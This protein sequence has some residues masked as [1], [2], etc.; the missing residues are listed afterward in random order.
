M[1]LTKPHARFLLRGSVLLIASLIL[2]WFVLADPLLALLR[3][4]VELLG[5]SGKVVSLTASGDWTFHFA[6]G[7][8]VVYFDIPR[9]DVLNFTYS[10]P[11]FW[12]IFLAAGDFRRSLRQFAIGTAIVVAAEA[13]MLLALVR[14]VSHEVAAGMLPGTQDAFGAWLL[15]LGKYVVVN[16]LPDAGPFLIALA[17]H[18]E[19]RSQILSFTVPVMQKTTSTPERKARRRPRQ[20]ASAR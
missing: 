14:I 11:V 7:P 16:V 15:R 2:W 19:L 17:L 4:L 5:G 8:R 3:W 9:D 20:P 10:L 1:R 18:R 13:L 6:A 12:A